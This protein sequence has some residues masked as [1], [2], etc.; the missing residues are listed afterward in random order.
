MQ[1]QERRGLHALDAKQELLYQT[2]AFLD[3]NYST[4][5]TQD[6]FYPRIT[7]R[8]TLYCS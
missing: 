3:L 2:I 1:F 4:E 6:S 8:A 5:G 7:I